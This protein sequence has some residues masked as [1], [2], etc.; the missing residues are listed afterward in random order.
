MPTSHSYQINQIVELIYNSKAKSVLDIGVGFGKYGFLAREYLELWD[1]REK[2]DDWQ[3][4]ID[5]I[6]AYPKYLT[7]IHDYIYNHIYQGNA[8]EVVPKLKNKYDLV[9]MIDVLEHFTYEEG[10][11]LLNQLL[12]TSRNLLISTPKDN[13][14]QEDSF[15]NPYETHKYEWTAKDLENLYPNTPKYIKSTT[16]STI[17]LLGKDADKIAKKVKDNRRDMLLLE[18]PALKIPHKAVNKLKKISKKS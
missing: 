16:F 7:P 18:Y 14:D 4:R 15:G 3:C 10:Q 2:Y 11:E 9:L 8:L 5:G 13:G 6:E 1:G 12:K 17:T